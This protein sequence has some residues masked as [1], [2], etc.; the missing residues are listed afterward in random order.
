MTVY[1]SATEQRI[2]DLNREFDPF[3][4]VDFHDGRFSLCAR[5]NDMTYEFGQAAFD[6]YAKEIGEEQYDEQGYITYGSGYDWESAF[7]EAFKDDPNLKRI[8]FDC[9]GCGFFCDGDDLDMM[10]DF[11]KRFRELCLD[12]ER[13]TPIVSAGMKNEAQRQAEE[14]MLTHTVRGQIMA[15]PLAEFSVRTAMGDFKI[16]CGE[17]KM[18]LDGR[19]TS[20]VSRTGKTE[21]TADEFLDQ[22][23][24]AVQQDLFDGNAYK[25]LADTEQEEILSPVLKM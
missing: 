19:K 11:G 17:G 3:Y 24:S 4:L 14:E 25:L 22:R 20:V 2:R 16:E 7:R 21:L 10:A 12:T 6:A 1:D 15:H 8:A 23:I 9:E 5:I 13:F 18:L